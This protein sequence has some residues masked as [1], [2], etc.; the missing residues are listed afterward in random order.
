MNVLDFFVFFIWVF[1]FHILFWIRRRRYPV[2]ELRKRH[3]QAFWLK[4]FATLCYALFVLYLSPGDTTSLYFPEGVNIQK[5]I[6]KDPSQIGVLFRKGEDFDQSKLTTIANA[7]YFTAESNFMVVRFVTIFSFFAFGQYLAIN[8]FFAMVAFSGIW[9][10]YRFFYEQYSHLG[11]QLAI[12]ILFLPTF[13]FWSSGILKDSLCIGAMG[14]ITY[15]LYAIFFARRRIIRNT[16]IVLF[17]GWLLAML[18]VYILVAYLPFLILYLI[19]SN[20]RLVR[21]KLARALLV[22]IFL[23]ASFAGFFR[24]T[25]NITEALGKFAG[26]GI[27][28]SIK[29]YQERYAAQENFS[30]SNFSLGV[31]F[32]GS[33]MS[34]VKIAPAAVVATL[35]R[36]FIWE[37]KKLSTLMSSLESLAMMLFTLY[38]LLKA[39]IFGSLKAFIK[40]P[41]IMYCLMFSLVFAI[42]VGS[43]TLNFG[44][45]VRYKI[46]CLPFY[47]IALFLILDYHRNKKSPAVKR[48]QV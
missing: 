47:L 17:F 3:R 44:S 39:G 32:D 5:M 12:A 2:P 26:E 41:M 25:E 40:S 20:L 16:L 14:W 34:L 8:L 6:I 23:T 30:E 15:S 24:A 28:E 37:S 45:L 7:G 36:P 35:Y 27:T 22:L 1:I 18:K 9:R 10:L 38:V 46:P 19:L 48:E 21:N 13:L 33:V 29:S 42:F 4:I 11:K 43:T 31:E